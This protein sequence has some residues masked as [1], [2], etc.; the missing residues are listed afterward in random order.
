MIEI[1]SQPLG[2]RGAIGSKARHRQ[3]AAIALQQGSHAIAGPGHVSCL[4][5]SSDCLVKESIK[6]SSHQAAWRIAEMARKIKMWVPVTFKEY[7]AA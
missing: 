3:L 4:G 1:Q 5:E 2:L 6:P 7:F